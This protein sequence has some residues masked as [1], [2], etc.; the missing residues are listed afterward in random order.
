MRR[1][2]RREP[3]GAGRKTVV[4]KTTRRVRPGVPRFVVRL[5]A[6]ADESKRVR[7]GN[8]RLRPTPGDDKRLNRQRLR[9]QQG[10][11]QTPRGIMFLHQAA[12]PRS[13]EHVYD[14]HY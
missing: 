1:L 2:E 14:S 10:Q 13:P 3:G 11:A 9:K 4:V 7:C 8:R 5:R 6:T 12:M